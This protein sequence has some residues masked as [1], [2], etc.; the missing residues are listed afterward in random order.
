MMAISRMRQVPPQ[1]KEACEQVRARIPRRHEFNQPLRHV[2][3][4]IVCVLVGVSFFGCAHD[5]R[6]MLSWS[7]RTIL[8]HGES[9]ESL[10]AM[11]NTAAAGR[12]KRARAIF[13]LFAD[14]IRPG[15]STTEV[16]RALA[17]TTWLKETNLYGVRVLGGWVPVEMALGD[18]VFCI[19]LFPVEMNKQ[20][21][22]W[23]IYFR[24]S[25]QL[26]DEDAKAILRGESVANDTRLV[27]FALCYPEKRQSAGGGSRLER[28]SRRGIH[29]YEM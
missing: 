25:G 16:H 8:P 17:N 19:H 1:R 12:A 26:R 18:T 7:D 2:H 11:A 4:F 9:V 6:E 10:N 21:S 23:V 24:L 29:V 20:W 14:H 5:R 22:P 28:F 27:E 13:T 15:A 3:L